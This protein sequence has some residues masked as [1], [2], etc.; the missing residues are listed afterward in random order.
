MA[1]NKV[2]NILVIGC[3]FALTASTLFADEGD[4]SWL[5]ML[6]FADS[7]PEITG[8]G[9]SVSVAENENTGSTSECLGRRQR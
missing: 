2:F 7:P 1:M 4:M 6:I 9:S 3:S 8:L 5:P